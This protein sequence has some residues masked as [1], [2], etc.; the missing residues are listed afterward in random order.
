MA[1]LEQGLSVFKGIYKRL[2]R[3]LTKE[4]KKLYTLNYQYLDPE[5]YHAVL[6]DIMPQEV[7]TSMGMQ[8]VMMPEGDPRTDFSPEDMNIYPTAD[9]S[10]VS[11]A[12]RL[13]KASGLMEMMQM[14]LPINPVIVTRKMLEAQQQEDIPELMTLPK[15][16]PSIEEKNF[17]LDVVK[18]QVEAVAKKAESIE[19]LAKAESLE[20]GSQLDMYR[21]IVD[22]MLR[23]VEAGN[24]QQGTNGGQTKPSGNTPKV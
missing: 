12:Q 14:G 1:V 3:A 16:Q 18:A 4:L 10:V 8:P 23:T 19:R 11:D 21:Q 13:A 5:Y 22:D 9:P 15:P 7:Q 20:V 24:S 2:H 17:Q 6:D